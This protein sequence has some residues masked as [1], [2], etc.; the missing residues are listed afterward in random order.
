MKP[1]R[2]LIFAWLAVFCLSGCLQVEKLVKLNADG[3][4]T[5]EETL[6]LSKASLAKIQ[7]M[8]SGFGGDK[9]A[10]GAKDFKLLDEEKLKQAAGK[11]GEGVTFVSAEP[12]SSD[13]GE[14]YK[15]IYAFTDISKL[16]IDQNPSSTMP[17]GDVGKGADSK[18]KKEPV[19]FRFTKGSP[20]ELSIAMPQPD[21]KPKNE[22]PPTGM[23]D[24]AMQMMQQMLKDMKVTIGVQVAGT[25][26]ET[27]AEFHD[28]SRV[29]LMEMDM[30]K[31]LADPEK[32]RSL[33]KANPQTLQEAKGIMKGIEGIKVETAPEVKVKFQ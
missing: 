29:T 4:G 28:A 30:N 1:I 16:K 14:G 17:V 31:V 7:Q 26:Q 6:V 23:E 3:S 2:I 18:A 8:M 25:I 21:F 15:A 20:A 13:Q 11:M 27:N 10:G 22:A 33:A 32:F 24:M 12:I 9:A 19:T 5:I